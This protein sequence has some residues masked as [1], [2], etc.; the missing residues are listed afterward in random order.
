MHMIFLIWYIILPPEGVYLRA[1]DIP[2]L[3]QIGGGK[4]T[5]VPVTAL[6]VFVDSVDVQSNLLKQFILEKNSLTNN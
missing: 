1:H 4:V 5:I 3:L 6:D 2:Q